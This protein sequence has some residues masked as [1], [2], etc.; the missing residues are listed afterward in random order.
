MLPAIIPLV[1]LS[2]PVILALREME[3]TA[4][5]RPMYTDTSGCHTVVVNSVAAITNA[6]SNRYR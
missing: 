3:S 6:S 4:Q 2:V 5:V 1:A